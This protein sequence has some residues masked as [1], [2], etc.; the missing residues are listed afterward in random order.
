MFVREEGRSWLARVEGNGRRQAVGFGG[1]MVWGK[2]FGFVE[3]RA[4]ACWSL[5]GRRLRVVSGIFLTEGED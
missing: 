5:S 3:A 2:C 4:E 1:T